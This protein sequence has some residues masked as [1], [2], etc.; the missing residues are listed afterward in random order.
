MMRHIGLV[1]LVTTT[2]HGLV[3]TQA[4][5]LFDADADHGVLRGHIARANSQWKDTPAG[6][7]ALAI[8]TGPNAYISPNWYAAKREHGKVVPTW[9]YI[10]IHAYGEI[11]FSEDR[12]KLLDIVTRLTEAHES[13]LE[14]PWKVGD[15]PAD[16]I[17]AMLKAIIAFEVKITRIESSWKL[18]QNRS[19]ADRAGAMA[20]LQQRGEEVAKE[21]ERLDAPPSPKEK[22]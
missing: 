16:Y 14:H 8:F 19:E 20:G 6:T 9:N 15:A 11:H 2:P 5:V 1:S 21:M 4:P 17:E 22:S 18:S 3:A 13:S 10:A 7:E 12:D